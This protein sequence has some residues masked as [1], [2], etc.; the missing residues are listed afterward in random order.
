MSVHTYSVV[1]VWY[2]II[3]QVLAWILEQKSFLRPI[4]VKENDRGRH[5]SAEKKNLIRRLKSYGFSWRKIVDVLKCSQSSIYNALKNESRHVKGIK[6][7]KTTPYMESMTMRLS[8]S[9]PE[10]KSVGNNR[11]LD[12][13]VSARQSEEFCRTSVRSY[14]ALLF[15]CPIQIIVTSSAT[16]TDIKY[17]RWGIM[18]IKEANENYW[19][20]S[21][22]AKLAVILASLFTQT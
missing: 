20:L 18:S 6:N 11:E 2:S 22:L 13:D 16:G 21:K 10:L 9:C 8:K 3:H 15:H 17:H 12:L 19:L 4:R 14:I 1:R 7:K 5:C